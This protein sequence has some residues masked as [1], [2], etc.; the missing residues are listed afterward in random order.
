MIPSF[1][2]PP[3]GPFLDMPVIDIKTGKLT[4]A[5]K[6]YFEQLDSVLT[7]VITKE[8][9]ALPPQDATTITILNTTQSIG[10]MLFNTT[11]SKEMVN[12]TGTFRTVTTT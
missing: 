12:E 6:T 9:I 4:D 2:I 11:T 3:I 8:G 1:Q 5:W 7:T 10:R